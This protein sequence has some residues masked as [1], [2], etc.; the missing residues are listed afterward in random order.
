MEQRRRRNPAEKDLA[1]QIRQ[2]HQPE[3]SELTEIRQTQWRPDERSDT[4]PIGMSRSIREL[5]DG[6]QMIITK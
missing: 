2:Q 1:D 6:G 4:L 3:Q 5:P